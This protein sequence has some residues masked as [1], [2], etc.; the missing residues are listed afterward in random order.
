MR[1]R[2]PLTVAMF[3]ALISRPG[4]LTATDKGRETTEEGVATRAMARA[5]AA[6]MLIVSV[7]LMLT[8]GSPA[9]QSLLKLTDQGSDTKYV[10]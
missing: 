1:K 4:S 6:R 7:L 10:L 8:V 3:C 9:V 5:S 2:R